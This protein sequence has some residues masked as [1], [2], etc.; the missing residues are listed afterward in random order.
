M[1]FGIL[2]CGGRVRGKNIFRDVYM[3]FLSM[4]LPFYASMM[5][6]TWLSCWFSA[7]LD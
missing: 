6:G 4:F 7:E 3:N 2:G 1:C 5:Q